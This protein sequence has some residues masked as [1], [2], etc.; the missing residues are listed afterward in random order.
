MLNHSESQYTLNH[1]AIQLHGIF[2]W[3]VRHEF[4]DPKMSTRMGDAM[5]FK[6]HKKLKIELKF[7]KPADPSV[8]AASSLDDQWR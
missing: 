4:D 6:R 1:L 3:G 5:K 7:R 8:S 2:S